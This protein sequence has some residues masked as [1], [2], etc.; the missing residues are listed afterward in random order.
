MY[1]T[2]AIGSH[3]PAQKSGRH[4]QLHHVVVGG[5]L[6]QQWVR[7]AQEREVGLLA[8]LV[9]DVELGRFGEITLIDHH[10][11]ILAALERYAELDR[12]AGRLDALFR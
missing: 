3:M 9:P 7:Q 6:R 5:Q 8:E 12:T 10:I 2:V 4:R 1:P 11:E